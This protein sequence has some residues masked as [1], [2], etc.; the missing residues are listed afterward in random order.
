VKCSLRGRRLF[1]KARD[2]GNETASESEKSWLGEGV[3][4]KNEYL[5]QERSF[6]RLLARLGNGKVALFWSQL[7]TRR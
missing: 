7:S 4:Q 2:K 1:S 5:T 6:A 3:G